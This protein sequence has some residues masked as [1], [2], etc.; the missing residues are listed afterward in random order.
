M[1][2]FKDV[3]IGDTWT[4]KVSGELVHVKVERIEGVKRI[5]LKNLNSKRTITRTP[6]SLR[7]LI[8]RRKTNNKFVWN[9]GNDVEIK[10]KAIRRKPPH[11]IAKQTMSARWEGP[12]SLC[13]C[14]HP[15]DGEGGAHKGIGGHGFC[16]AAGC[17]CLQFTW[18]EFL[19]EFE[20][21]LKKIEKGTK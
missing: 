15:G 18:R 2:K 17:K 6:R 19:P 9:G 16:T 8:A 21:A 4:A 3:K 11:L 7:R 1:A 10:V 14:G 12:R 13:E 20:Q 5:V